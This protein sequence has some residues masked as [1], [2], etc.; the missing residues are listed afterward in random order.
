MG[1]TLMN[2]IL[3]TMCEVYTVNREV[4]AFN[5]VN[6]SF[7]TTGAMVESH[8]GCSPDLLPQMKKNEDPPKNL[9]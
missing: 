9:K 6:F 8:H 7:S 5:E 2:V 4:T 1:Q 3:T